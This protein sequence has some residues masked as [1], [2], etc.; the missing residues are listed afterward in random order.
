MS[1][2]KSTHWWLCPVIVQLPELCLSKLILASQKT[3]NIFIK[4][5]A[6][7]TV[8]KSSWNKPHMARILNLL[9]IMI[10]NVLEIVLAGATRCCSRDSDIWQISVSPPMQLSNEQLQR[11]EKYVWKSRPVFTNASHSTQMAD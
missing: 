1:K 3:D 11:R 10:E 6:A 4:V 5:A 8:T 7:I 9:W 2:Y